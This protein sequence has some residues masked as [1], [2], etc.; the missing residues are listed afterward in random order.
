MSGKRVCIIGAGISGLVTAKVMRDDGFEVVVFEKADAIGGV[1]EAT[2]TYL[3]LRANNPRETYEYSEL[4]YPKSADHYPSA[5]Q[6]RSY[7]D[8]FADAFELRPRIR[9]SSEVVAVTREA[10]S[11]A[12]RPRFRVSV[13]S[14]RSGEPTQEH[15]F[16]F[17][18]VCNGVF[19]V[20]YIPDIEGSEQFAGQTLHSSEFLDPQIVEGK[21]V[22]V[23]GGGKSA[24]DC[25]SFATRSAKVCTLNFLTPPWVLPSFFWGGIRSDRVLMTRLTEIF[26]PYPTQTRLEAFLHTRC[27]RLVQLYWALIGGLIR[28]RLR[29]PPEMVPDPPK[30][31]RLGLGD[32]FFVAMREGKARTLRGRIR[33]FSSPSTLELE[34]GEQIDADIVIYGTGWQQEVSF[35]D[36]ELQKSVQRD[37]GFDLYRHILPLDVPELGFVGYASSTANQLTAEIAAHWLSQHFRG[38]LTL[39]SHAVMRREIRRVRAW[40]AHLG[41]ALARGYHIGPNNR[42]Y[43]DELLSDMGLPTQRT[44]NPF[45]EYL[46]PLRPERYR[47]VTEQRRSLRGARPA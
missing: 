25:A 17:V 40:G 18:V 47:N 4:P 19:S 30:V 3:G 15:A 14:G 43:V 34:G 45:V 24:I 32:E 12:S 29:T 44:K 38:E 37:G 2:R 36:T 6:V 8:S 7:L 33:R 16:D 41:E 27:P 39:P 10:P 20:P 31:E 28:A 5:A 11:E 35:L 42:H 26:Q 23:I 1:W 22:A 46:G 9:L 13:R 21:R